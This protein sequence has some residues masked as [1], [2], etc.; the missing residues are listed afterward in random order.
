[1]IRCHNYTRIIHRGTRI[2]DYSA[3]LLMCLGKKG[4]AISTL[5]QIEIDHEHKQ[6]HARNGISIFL[7]SLLIASKRLRSI[8]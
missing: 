4:L 3:G 8:P 5:P 6:R 2:I 1:M 7:C